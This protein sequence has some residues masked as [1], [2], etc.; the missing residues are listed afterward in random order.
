MDVEAD[1]GAT[2]TRQAGS[3]LL[4]KPSDLEAASASSSADSSD[5]SDSTVASLPTKDTADLAEK[6]KVCQ[7]TYAGFTK[8]QKAA[9]IHVTLGINVPPDTD[10]QGR[11]VMLC[12]KRILERNAEVG[13]VLEI[14][15]SRGQRRWCDNC[16][17]KTP[18]SIS[19]IIFE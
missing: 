17:S 10:E 12:S 1:E 18:E 13:P 16:R 11:F 15:L 8:A 5:E 2:A 14:R 6:I 3:R 19:S 4:A 7:E 9:P